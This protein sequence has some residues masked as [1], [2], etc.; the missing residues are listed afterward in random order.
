M[1]SIDRVH[2]TPCFTKASASY[3]ETAALPVAD[4]GRY[5]TMTSNCS[6]SRSSSNQMHALPVQFHFKQRFFG[7]LLLPSIFMAINIF[8]SVSLLNIVRHVEGDDFLSVLGM[9]LVPLSIL[10]I[11]FYLLSA[12]TNPGL[13]IGNEQVQL[14][15][16]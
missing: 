6:T 13:L 8:T 11:T 16:A 5:S 10:A 4:A 2:D 15:K 12:F 7:N 9:L 3:S 1:Q 14:Q